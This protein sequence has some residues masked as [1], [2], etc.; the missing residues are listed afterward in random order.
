MIGL[1]KSLLV[2]SQINLNATTTMLV[3]LSPAK[4][5]CSFRAST[6]VASCPVLLDKTDILLQVMKGKSKGDIKVV[7]W[8]I[9][10][11]M[12]SI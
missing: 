12:I 4:S 10:Q 5:M 7:K 2:T 9:D 1:A 11:P 3:L 8:V 6:Y